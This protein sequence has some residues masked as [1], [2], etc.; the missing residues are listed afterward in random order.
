MLALEKST[1]EQA[2]PCENAPQHVSDMYGA[3]HGLLHPSCAV[4]SCPYF[5]SGQ[6]AGHF[7]TVYR[8]V[9]LW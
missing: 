4:L 8:I 2:Y 1:R 3:H 6:L 9:T 5:L 7:L